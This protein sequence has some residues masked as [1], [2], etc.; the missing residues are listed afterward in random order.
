MTAGSTETHRQADAAPSVSPVLRASE[1]ALW[2]GPSIAVWA[3]TGGAVRLFVCGYFAEWLRWEDRYS[4][5]E[6]LLSPS[7]A[8]HGMA[9][10]TAAQQALSKCDEVSIEVD[11]DDGLDDVE[12]YRNAHTVLAS[13]GLCEDLASI[14]LADDLPGYAS[15]T[16]TA[17]RLPALPARLSHGELLDLASAALPNRQRAA[18]RP[19]SFCERRCRLLLGD[20]ASVVLWLAPEAQD[21]L[22]W[23]HGELKAQQWPHHGIP[24]FS[25]SDT[26]PPVVSAGAGKRALVFRLLERIVESEIYYL[27]YLSTEIEQV[28]S[29]FYQHLRS[30]KAQ[31]ARTVI[32]AQTIDAHLD[33]VAQLDRYLTHARG[34]STRLRRRIEVGM[35]SS[36]RDLECTLLHGSF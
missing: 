23:S 34:I 26:Q 14:S 15:V 16:P 24:G 20:S 6:P 29:R 4:G 3:R 2:Q 7:G 30:D 33:T 18:D 10:S 25:V 12:T 9:L 17:N 21:S 27:R 5:A 36:L 13:I 32:Q 31:A 22:H 8:A 11:F 28:E 1:P 19:L 35:L